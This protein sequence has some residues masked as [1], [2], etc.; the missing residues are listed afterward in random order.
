MPANE[1]ETPISIP[2]KCKI[3]QQQQKF[4]LKRIYS[5]NGSNA[6]LLSTIFFTSSLDAPLV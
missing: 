2:S 3:K 1:Y 4:E 5:G 6:A